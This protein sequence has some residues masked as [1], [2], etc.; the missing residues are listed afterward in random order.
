[1]ELGFN[2][3]HILLDLCYPAD[4][5]A[6]GYTG[7]AFSGTAG[8]YRPNSQARRAAALQPRTNG[9]HKLDAHFHGGSMWGGGGGG[10]K[11][12][13]YDDPL[14]AL[15]S[16]AGRVTANVANEVG[17]SIMGLARGLFSDHLSC[18]QVVSNLLK[19]QLVC[20]PCWIGSS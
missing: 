8:P 10:G 13:L 6:R 17:A 20:D 18:L 4:L 15:G 12:A 11:A 9:M 16:H 5:A 19:V 3:V 7:M 14:D 1:L 2:R